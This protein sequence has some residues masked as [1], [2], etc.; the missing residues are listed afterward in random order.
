MI[1]VKVYEVDT[2]DI[3]EAFDAVSDENA[4]LPPDQGGFLIAVE[5]VEDNDTEVF[6]GYLEIYRRTYSG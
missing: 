1:V 2:E 5:T 6:L 4:D 3:S